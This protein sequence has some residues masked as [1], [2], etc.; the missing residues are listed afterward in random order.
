MVIA[1]TLTST[2]LTSLF[3]ILTLFS[4]LSMAQTDPLGDGSGIEGYDE[5]YFELPEHQDQSAILMELVAPFLIITI[6]LQIV[7]GKVLAHI[8]RD[9]VRTPYGMPYYEDKKPKVRKYSIL[10]AAST[11]LA[12]IPTPFWE[13][14]TYA[15]VSLPVIAMSLIVLIVVYGSYNVI[16]ALA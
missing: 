16:K 3:L 5:D 8:L 7:Y 2:K 4:M 11:G 12:L 14:I 10:L 13:Y 1:L 15:V 6:I 9:E